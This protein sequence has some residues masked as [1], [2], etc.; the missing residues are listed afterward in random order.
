[1]KRKLV[2]GRISKETLKKL[3]LNSG[4]WKFEE[5]VLRSPEM[6]D[7]D[8]MSQRKKKIAFL[9]RILLIRL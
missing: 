2:K 1:M 9:F 8:D 7:G 5:I 6:N 4:N 3:H